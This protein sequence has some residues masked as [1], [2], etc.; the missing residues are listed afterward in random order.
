VALR[1]AKATKQPIEVIVQFG[2]SVKILH[3]DAPDG[4]LYPHLERIAG[5]ADVLSDILKPRGA[6]P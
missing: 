3:I 6:K 4:V 5:T 2:E 1:E